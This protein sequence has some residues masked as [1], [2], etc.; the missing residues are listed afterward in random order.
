M[1]EAIFLGFSVFLLVVTLFTYKAGYQYLYILIAAFSL[2]MNI[3]VL[4][5]FTLFGYF[6]T[7]GNAL[8]GAMFLITDIIGEHHGKKQAYIGVM[9]GFL[10]S[11]FFVIASQTLIHFAPNEY[12]FAQEHISALFSILPRV[13]VGSLLAFA[14]AQSL[15]VWLFSFIKKLTGHKFLWLRN[16]GSTLI[17]QFVDTVI[18]TAVGLTTFS[19][20]P[21]S[22]AGFIDAGIFWEVTWATYIIKVIFA[23]ID[24]PFLYLSRHFAPK[25]KVS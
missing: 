8:Y 12:D 15:D 10:T 22:L 2:M 3:F 11:L 20:L 1:N 13:L 18:F 16:N 9:I 7:G 17:S 6:V 21:E 19:F 23:L 24:T 4:K 14:I 25:K 5:Q